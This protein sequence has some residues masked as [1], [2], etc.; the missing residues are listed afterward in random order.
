MVFCELF[1]GWHRNPLAKGLLDK[2]DQL[3]LPFV[4]QRSEVEMWTVRTPMPR[5]G[6]KHFER[7]QDTVSTEATVFC[8]A[9]QLCDCRT[10][11][12]CPQKCRGQTTFC[13]DFYT[14]AVQLM[15]RKLQ[16]MTSLRNSD[17]AAKAT[18]ASCWVL[19]DPLGMAENV[20]SSRPVFDEFF[21]MNHHI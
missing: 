21:A 9:L 1:G 8:C 7:G 15:N 12:T 3:Y 17:G 14:C 5:W 6:E 4:G 10:V 11:C 16:D 13:A 20:M 2:N 19:S 18:A